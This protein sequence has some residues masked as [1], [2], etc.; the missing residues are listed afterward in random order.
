MLSV[1]SSDQPLAGVVLAHGAG[2]GQRSRFM[3]EAANALAA[4]RVTVATFDFPYMAQGRSAPDKGPVLEAHWRAV[5]GAAQ[6]DPAFAGLPLFIG[7]KSMG[8]R[9]ASQVAAQ[10]VDGITG[11]VYF[12]Y[13]LH[14]PG[15][16]DQRRDRHLPDIR[17][18]MLFVQGTR[19]AFGSAQEIREL[20]PRLNGR[21]S[22]FEVPDGDH[23]FN[24]RLK[25]TGKRPD[26]VM[27]AIFDAA[28]AFIQTCAK[29]T[30]R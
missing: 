27:V 26:A 15:R 8:G 12:G 22:I 19:D 4:R 16:L 2:G 21:T 11:L 28:A 18:P 5:I 25:V 10:H 1:Y 17:E 7:G 30:S 20:L 3:V 6:T 23:S 13:P 9:I 14:P 24:V 29:S